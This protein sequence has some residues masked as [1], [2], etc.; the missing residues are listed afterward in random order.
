MNWGELDFSY[1]AFALTEYDNT[2]NYK[3]IH[4]TGSSKPWSFINKHPYK[5]VYWKYLWKTPYKWTIPTDLTMLNILKWI[6]PNKM[7]VTL[8][9]Y[10]K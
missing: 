2:R 1:N 3:I 10:R 4:Y 8:K 7:K 9:K 5:Y 6:I